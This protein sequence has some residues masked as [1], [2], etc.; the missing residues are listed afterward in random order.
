MNQFLI[1]LDIGHFGK[2]HMV[3]AKLFDLCNP[4]LNIDRG[5]HYDGSL[6]GF[7]GSGS[8]LHFLEFIEIPS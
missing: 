6:N 7:R 2:K 4:A 5:F 1:D 8:Q 3:A